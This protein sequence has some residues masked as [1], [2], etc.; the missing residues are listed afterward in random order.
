VRDPITDTVHLDFTPLRRWSYVSVLGGGIKIP[1]KSHF[2]IAM[3]SRTYLYDNP[4]STLISAN[5]S[6]PQTVAFIVA[7]DRAAFQF[8]STIPPGTLVGSPP[9]PPGPISSLSGPPIS[10]FKSFT[11]TGLQRRVI[12][13]GG[14]FW[15][16]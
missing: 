2:G 14:P 4:I 9:G 11:E 8:L 12:I 10:G 7:D 6:E 15:R 5:H 1:L 3:E 13:S 16:F